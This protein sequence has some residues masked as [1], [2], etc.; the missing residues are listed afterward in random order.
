MDQIIRVI[1]GFVLAIGPSVVLCRIVMSLGVVDAPTEARK[2]QATPVPTMGGIAVALSVALAISVDN[3]LITGEF[4]PLL[5]I[6]GGGATGAL[7]VGM[8]DDILGLRAV[9]K[10]AAL[11]AISLGVAW[12]GLWP[13]VFAPWPGLELPM[14]VWLAIAGAALWLLV[15]M[16][17][18]N[19]MDG[20][21]GLAM[22]M[23]AIA[24]A[25][26]CVIGA[27]VGKWDVAVTA[28]ALTGGLCGF[29]VW[30]GSGRLFAGD[31]GA[32][33]VGALLAGLGLEIVR[34]RPDLLLVP[35]M[36]L[37]PFLS[38]VLLTL[39]WRA[40][41]GKKLFAAHRDHVYQIAIKAGLKHWQVSAV[42]AVWALNAAIV[43][44]LSALLTRQ[45]P[46]TLFVLLLLV[47]TWLHLKI[48]RA[49]VRNGLVG[50]EIA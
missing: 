22:G 21:N 28:G 9:L 10:L 24:A 45:I 42:H 32:L 39:A 47:S 43:A 23:A 33:S 49:G 30:N 41:H 19:F 13:E 38:D 1:L 36:L 34:A 44:I 20:A 15:V 3:E 48:R 46:I 8:V 5:L 31:A 12:F 4:N 6:V 7:I 40:K 16:N 26:Y 29:L 18:V 50:K 25:G 2:T 11:T 37:L 14:P 27:I 35:P 17:A